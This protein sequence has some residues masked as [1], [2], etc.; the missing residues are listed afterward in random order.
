MAV[1]P[2][3]MPADMVNPGL[4]TLSQWLSP[5]FPLGAFA[6]S[7]G[8]EQAVGS[9]KVNG[10]DSLPDWQTT[11]LA[12]GAGHAFAAFAN[13][14][15]RTPKPA[16]SAHSPAPPSSPISPRC[17]TRP[18]TPGSSAHDPTQR[19]P[20]YRHRR[21]DGRHG[22][23]HDIRTRLIPWQTPGPELA[24]CLSSVRENIGAAAPHFDQAPRG[25]T[26]ISGSAS[27]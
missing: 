6:Y 10:R 17:A 8:V 20:S 2:D 13:R 16:I 22:W 25:K 4:L 15:R 26:R 24:R 21:P 9:S 3:I 11:V 19:S 12:H 5:A 14:S 27:P 7:H 1:R 18:N 23:P